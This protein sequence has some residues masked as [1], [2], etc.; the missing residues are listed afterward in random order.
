[1]KKTTKLN[2]QNDKILILGG[3]G[4]VGDSIIRLLLNRG[5]KKIAVV[6]LN[7]RREIQNLQ[8]IRKKYKVSIKQYWANILVPRELKNYTFNKILSVKK[9]RKVLIDSYSEHFT[10]DMIKKTFLY[11][12][13][14]DFK[15]N[16]IIDCINTATQCSYINYIDNQF[17][18]SGV[19][20]NILLR[21]F[22]I[23]NSI[24]DNSFWSKNG[25]GMKIKSYLKVGTSG[26]G[27][28]GLNIPFTHGEE[29]PS[30]SLLNK[31]AMSG[32]Q[33]S[34]L[35]AI[36]NNNFGVHIKQVIPATAIFS[37]RV[38]INGR[39]LNILSDSL[40][41]KSK[42]NIHFN[43]DG[44]ESGGYALEEFRLLSDPR[45]MGFI[46]SDILA[47]KIV[48]ELE[49]N[50]GHDIIEGI[51]NSVIRSSEESKLLRE[52]ILSA[53]EKLLKLNDVKCIAHGKLGP[54]K[55]GK[56]LYEA[57][58]FSDYLRKHRNNYFKSNSEK[59]SRDLSKLIFKDSKLKREI[60]SSGLIIVYNRDVIKY[61]N[62]GKPKIPD[63]LINLD[64][65]NCSIWQKRF[66][67][68]EFNKPGVTIPAP[69]EIISSLILT[70][71]ND[72]N[73]II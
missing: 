37:S 51:E 20:L 71:L 55:I 15:P 58:I 26:V 3:G 66:K 39:K 7:S 24:L 25:V 57:K 5:I 70:N 31:V 62:K 49:C 56:L 34:I 38:Y 33:T 53:G 8:Y 43:I 21:Y 40:K 1:M 17:A 6:S 61:K 72:F 27:G 60:A 12:V 13:I 42:K 4:L 9:F 32:V 46:D 59:I 47:K 65:K 63:L 2:K 14:K 28:M 19:G 73:K 29:R 54:R 69:G 30:L 45:Q 22:Q 44:G 10:F 48:N 23:L 18:N 41:I 68:L 52:K 35:Y 16:Y 67:T 36:K 11:D 64:S 50:D